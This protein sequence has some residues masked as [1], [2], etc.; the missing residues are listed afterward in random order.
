M[1]FTE[2]RT[3]HVQRAKYYAC[4]VFGILFTILIMPAQ[5]LNVPKNVNRMGEVYSVLYYPVPKEILL[6]LLIPIVYT[7][8]YWWNNKQMDKKYGEDKYENNL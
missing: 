8:Y 3:K 1:G 2:I 5:V 6:I 4:F 7:I